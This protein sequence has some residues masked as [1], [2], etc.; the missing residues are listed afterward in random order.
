M[1]GVLVRNT[2]WA[3]TS[4]FYKG[5]SIPV[6][7]GAQ[8][9]TLP[10]NDINQIE[11]VFSENVVV[12]Q[13]DLLLSGV[14]TSAYNVSGGTFRY[15]ATTFT[16]TWTLAQSI[17][18]D[19][20]LL[21]LN[22]DGSNPIEDAAGNRLDGE[23]MNPAS[24]ADTSGSVYPSGNG[25]AGG[26]FDF[27]FNVLPGDAN[28]DGVVNIS[29]LTALSSQWQQTGQ[30]SLSADFNGD[31][32]VDI[33]DLVGLASSWQATLPSGQPP[34]GHP[35][36]DQPATL[37]APS[38]QTCINALYYV[39]SSAWAMQR[40]TSDGLAL[41]P[42]YALQF[43]AATLINMSDA[44]PGLEAAF[45]V[46][47]ATG[48]PLYIPAGAYAINTPCV[49]RSNNPVSIISDP[50]ACFYNDIGL[51]YNSSTGAY[52]LSKT[53]YKQD[54]QSDAACMLTYGGLPNVGMTSYGRI[55]Q[56]P[57]AV[58]CMAFDGAYQGRIA[59]AY[60]FSGTLY[61]FVNVTGDIEVL[62]K[63]E[64]ADTA[65]SFCA[66]GL[67]ELDHVRFQCQDITNVR[68]AIRFGQIS[69][70]N[71]FTSTLWQLG[72]LQLP[73]IG[74]DCLNVIE[75]GPNISGFKN[76]QLP[77][78]DVESKAWHESNQGGSG[79]TPT[80][81]LYSPGA[82]CE[83]QNVTFT[84]AYFE[85]PA[86]E[87]TDLGTQY[88]IA[89]YTPTNP[90]I[91][92][93]L[94]FQDCEI[95]ALNQSMFY[96]DPSNP[97]G[98]IYDDAS[99]YPGKAP[100]PVMGSGGGLATFCEPCR[101]GVTG[102]NRVVCNTY[103]LSGSVSYMFPVP[104]ASPPTVTLVSGSGVTATV[105]QYGITLSANSPATAAF[106][107]STAA[108]ASDL[109]INSADKSVAATTPD[110]LRVVGV[111]LTSSAASTGGYSVP[112]G[113]GV[114]LLPISETNLNQIKV[115]FSENVTVDQSDLSLTG[116]NVPWYN[117][118]GGTFSYD[119]SNFTATWTL[120]QPI[121]DDKLTLTLNADGSDPI[122]DA[123]GNH[124]DGDWSNPLST[125]DTSGSVYPSGD[126]T[127]GGNF[128]FCFNVLPGDANQDGVVN[129][130]DLTALG[131]QWQQT[132]Q[133]AVSADVNNDGRVD[134][135]DLTALASRWQQT[136]PSN[137]PAILIDPSGRTCV[138][139]LYY[140][141]DG[142]WQMTRLD[143]SGQPKPPYA[144]QLNQ[145]TLWGMADAR[146]GLDAA[147]AAADAA[148]IPLYIP[149]GGYAIKTPVVWRSNNP[150]SIFCDPNACFY[151]CLDLASASSPNPK[152][153]YYGADAQQ[154]AAVM[155]TYGG[156][157]DSLMPGYDRITQLPA[158]VDAHDTDVFSCTFYR[159]VNVSGDIEVLGKMVGAD[160]AVSFCAD[161][162]PELDHVRFQ[163][164]DITN[165]R[166]AIRFGQISDSNPFTSTLWQLGSLQLPVIGLDCLNVIELGPNI[167]GFKNWQ[168]PLLDV[169]SKA[170]HE[171]NQGGSG[172]TPTYILYSP[173][174]LCEV[175]NVTFTN[176]YF[177]PPAHEPTDL[178]TQYLI[179][180]YTPTNPPI[181]ATLIFQDCEIGALNQSMFYYD[182]SNPTGIIYDDASFYPGKAPAPVMGSGGGVATFCEPCRSGVTG[183][184][185]VVCNTYLLS[186]T[187]SYMFPVP[188]ASPPTVTLVSGSGVTA[189]VTQYGI[190]LSANSPATAA[191]D[192]STGDGTSAPAAL[193]SA[194]QVTPPSSEPAA[195]SLPAVAPLLMVA[196]PTS[197]TGAAAAP[198]RS[199]VMSES[200]LAGYSVGKRSGTAT[201]YE[202]DVLKSSALTLDS[203]AIT[204]AYAGDTTFSSSDDSLSVLINATV[205]PAPLIV[206]VAWA[207]S[208]ASGIRDAAIASLLGEW[209]QDSLDLS[210]SLSSALSA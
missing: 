25:T 45:A 114:Q 183:Y 46:A 98:I 110:A 65:V 206:R 109:A 94:I 31:G 168:L 165:V 196:T 64:N 209:S 136:L 1:T 178:G 36:C 140:V 167:S 163:C 133:G 22:A 68:T 159:L 129:I 74:L 175:Q 95:G 2:G 17:G 148:G 154:D 134:I 204:A 192:I 164:Q 11:V 126:G 58:S 180:R 181:R 93:T 9:A 199:N 143:A 37:V 137:Q 99:F 166:T 54:A 13:S 79:V 12:N 144:L 193:L 20:L 3:P 10:W 16:A 152:V 100:A 21:A 112:V 43:N 107:I 120:P 158:A 49:W 131:S 170:W 92:A 29:D 191:F 44:T 203:D 156:L 42:P 28:Q 6:G 145:S 207:N 157:K 197:E 177:E 169:E 150:V 48:L 30:G 123:L 139:A 198:S 91:R 171:S 57:A 201:M 72:S 83:V 47:D 185:R 105:T 118:A 189:T 71:P 96:Y 88:L 210:G 77:L 194:S 66:D 50:N 56:L 85:P 75:L 147:F 52:Y 113:S 179:A 184:N 87:P 19:K 128:V 33:G 81:I 202:W 111:F 108:E 101:S 102:Y 160:T 151:N 116:I 89:R 32:R 55:T 24:T 124:L 149:A 132:G 59:P 174:A 5:Y 121:G 161:G 135:S 142:A 51:A 38:G 84:N 86:H 82:P 146:A 119:A 104:F 205:S 115:T 103:L 26:N 208:P 200:A 18:P 186:G 35:V 130:S 162:V 15:D 153:G 187:V 70:S 78:L 7:S 106:D 34:S 138:N 63:M 125:A 90:P 60:L 190:T 155:L 4:P 41:K 182:P 97:T 39:D 141:Q 62:G 23:W 176:A 69:D 76:W 40:A 53:Y 188:F 80:Y 73:V 122:Q 27:R 14:N 173:G 172:V 8:L 117:A 127:A 195:G 67:P 61:R